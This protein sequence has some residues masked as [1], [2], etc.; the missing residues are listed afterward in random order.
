MALMDAAAM[1]VAMAPETWVV[2]K[3]DAD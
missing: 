3:P 1:A 2:L